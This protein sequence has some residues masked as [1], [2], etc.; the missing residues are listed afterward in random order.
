MVS[1]INPILLEGNDHGVQQAAYALRDGKLVA[2][3]TETVYGLG[4]N[5]FNLRAVSRIYEVKGRPSFNP[6]ILHVTDF[7]AAERLGYFNLYARSLASTFWPGPLTL[8]LPCRKGTRISSSATAGLGTIAIRIPSHPLARRFLELTGVPVAAPS[9]NRSGRISSTRVQHVSSAF[10]SGIDV[11]LDGGPASIG[12]ESTIVSCDAGGVTL[13]RP[14]GLIR[15]EIEHCLGIPISTVPVS[16]LPCAPG[17]LS[18]HYA[19]RAVLRLNATHVVPGEA[20]LT[21]GSAP[22]AESSCAGSCLNLSPSGD[23]KEAASNLFDFLHFLDKE[24][25]SAIAVVPIPSSGL[26]ETI[27]DRLRRAAAPR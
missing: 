5:A 26:G 21:F 27:N 17:Q 25:V 13:L 20:L 14:G 23:L 6:L 15:E 22:V 12:L 8:V 4:A 24:V 2:F 1:H 3:P 18:S 9:A 11:I 10:V 16:L 7:S 19:P